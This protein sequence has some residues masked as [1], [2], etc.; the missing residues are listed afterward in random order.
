MVGGNA[1]G[2]LLLSDARAFWCGDSA[3][4]HAICHFHCRQ[5]DIR[6]GRLG[7]KA[8]KLYGSFCWRLSDVSLHLSAVLLGQ[9][10]LRARPALSIVASEPGDNHFSVAQSSPP[11]PPSSPTHFL[12]LTFSLPPS[13]RIPQPH[14][15]TV[16]RRALTDLPPPSFH[17][18]PRRQPRFRAA[19]PLAGS[20]QVNLRARCD[21][22]PPAFEVS[23]SAV[24][25]RTQ[26]RC[27]VAVVKPHP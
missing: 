23:Y 10:S 5:F 8:I 24:A 12:F 19:F 9:G 1:T 6:C 21:L 4:P 25:H 3:K 26:K 14:H 11:P 20:G 17:W 15:N 18:P 7:R 13:P 16:K 22:M 27:R 2:S